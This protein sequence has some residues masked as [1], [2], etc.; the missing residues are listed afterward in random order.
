MP[1]KTA[2]KWVHSA[3]TVV[4]L[5]VVLG[6]IWLNHSPDPRSGDRLQRAYKLSDSVWLYMTVNDQGGA[7]VPTLY[8]YYLSNKLKGNDED[9][10]VQLATK[11]PVIVGTGS[12][13]HAEAGKNG[14]VNIAYSGKV[15][16]LKENVSNLQFTVTP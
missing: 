12:I 3:V 8:R 13:T 14:E 10:L 7:T 4:L 6:F 16:T 1:F 5:I 15:I 9:I 2:I 11:S